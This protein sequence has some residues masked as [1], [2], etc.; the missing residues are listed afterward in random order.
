MIARRWAVVWILLTLALF[1]L[2]AAVVCAVDPYFHYH[3]PVTDRWYYELNNE[4]YQN[5]GILHHFDY[6][7]VIIG[8]S[9]SHNF[10]TSEMN[11]LFGVNAV[12]TTFSGGDY[13]EMHDYLEL[14][15]HLHPDLKMVLRS[16]DGVKLM[17]DR[18]EGT[19]DD[20]TYS[21]LF[22]KNP[23]NDVKYLLN[24]DVV[25][26][27]VLPMIVREGN[28]PG[29]TSFDEY[30]SWQFVSGINQV[31]VDGVHTKESHEPVHLTA[32][33]KETIYRNITQNITSLAEEYPD[34]QFYCF[35]APYS[36]LWWQYLAEEGTIYQRVEAEEYAAQLMLEYNN[37]H[38]FCFSCR[39]DIIS[40]LNNYIDT[41]HYGAWVNSLMLRWMA[42]GQYELTK[43]NLHNYMQKELEVYLNYD[44]VGLN[45]QED[46]VDDSVAEKL[47]M[48]EIQGKHF[49]DS[50]L[51][52]S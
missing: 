27:R 22:D 15:L 25:F 2:I 29:I 1:A 49:P 18:M 7:S 38:L 48:D 39:T 13:S 42:D 30:S 34:T 46:Y 8:N 36:I 14:A 6:D 40:D 41:M 4:R 24:R 50:E 31:T 21:Y 47:V 35:F 33:Q 51:W 37:I 52:K 5:D 16:L 32:E 26:G 3:A 20:P 45:A 11:E 17:L 12:K 28:P 44:Y 9:M 43:E 19:L 10:K 23:V